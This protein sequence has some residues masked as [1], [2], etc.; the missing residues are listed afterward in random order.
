MLNKPR[1]VRMSTLFPRMASI[2]KS[3]RQTSAVTLGTMLSYDLAS[4]RTRRLDRSSRASLSQH[5][6]T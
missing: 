5:T 6:E 3:S 1:L 4:M 2:E